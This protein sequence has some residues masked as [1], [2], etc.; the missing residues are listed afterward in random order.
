M[1]LKL[2]VITFWDLYIPNSCGYL[3]VYI[4]ESGGNRSVFRHLFE[5]ISRLGPTQ[6][7]LTLFENV[8]TQY[9]QS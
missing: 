3:V 2:F 6:F 7:F 4:V 9:N 5:R 8:T 1:I